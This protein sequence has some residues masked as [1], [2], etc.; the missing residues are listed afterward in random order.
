MLGTS[1]PPVRWIASRI[2]RASALNADSAL[3]KGYTGI[4]PVPS[5]RATINWNG[6]VVVVLTPQDVDMEGHARSNG[7][8]VEYVGDHLRREVADLFALQVQVRHAIRPRA[9]IDDRPRQGLNDASWWWL[10]SEFAPNHGQRIAVPHPR[11]R[12]QCRNGGCRAPR[13]EPA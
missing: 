3:F 8:R 13:R 4:S 2:A 5:P 7:E 9:D 11:A 12:T 6:P 10:R 1:S